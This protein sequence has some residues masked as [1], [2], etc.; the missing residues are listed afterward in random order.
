[1]DASRYAPD[2]LPAWDG[3]PPALRSEAFAEDLLEPGPSVLP[4]QSAAAARWIGARRIKH[5]PLGQT[6]D[7]GGVAAWLRRGLGGQAA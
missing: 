2:P 7:R 3:L 4:S 5:A 1:M 6:V